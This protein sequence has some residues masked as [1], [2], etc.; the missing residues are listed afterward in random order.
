MASD[1]DGTAGGDVDFLVIIDNSCSMEDEQDA[2]DANGESLFTSAF[3]AAVNLNVA[4]INTTEPTFIAT[5]D[6]TTPDAAGVF[7]AAVVQ[8]NDGNNIE[9]PFLRALEAMEQQPD[10]RRPG[11][12]LSLLILSDE[13]DQ[14]PVLLPAVIGGLG[15]LVTDLAFL[16]VNHISG[17]MTGCNGES[18]NAIP[19]PRLVLVGDA[20]GGKSVSICDLAWDLGSLLPDEIP[21]DCDDDNPDV[22]AGAEELCDELDNDC[23]GVADEDGDGDGFGVC[24]EDCDDSN[25]NVF[26]G[27]LEVCDGIDNDCDGVL[28]DDELDEDGD[29]VFAC[30]DCDDT[31]V[32]RFPGAMEICDD[33]IDNNCD[34]VVDA[35]ADGVDTDG[36]LLDECEGDCDDANPQTFS[37]APDHTFDGID[38]DCDGMTDTIDDEEVLT[39]SDLTGLTDTHFLF[40]GLANDFSICGAVFD[41]VGVSSDGFLVFGG[42]DAVFDNTASAEDLDAYAPSIAP[43]WV[44]LFP[45]DGGSIA[46]VIRP[47]GSQSYFWQD[48][49]VTGSAGDNTS[50]DITLEADGTLTMNVRDGVEAGGFMG[51]S[52]GE[53][54]EG[55]F[56]GSFDIDLSATPGGMGMWQNFPSTPSPEG[57]WMFTGL[58]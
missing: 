57:T 37:G 25:V 42:T 12:G 47:D 27:A 7:G 34:G 53:A 40:S 11:A 52:C 6:S 4:V 51:I 24:L 39:L 35:D 38:N 29:G 20:T 50:F 23:D 10:W 46:S 31:N 26:P 36:D 28:P 13:D 5:I 30:E 48:I 33:T 55:D 16:E 41:V 19:A 15:D 54:T 32:N 17:L 1:C 49:P 18:G 9:Q 21:A 43:G 8:G 3:A 56:T 2:L 14:S 22:F 45:P 58:E 44:D